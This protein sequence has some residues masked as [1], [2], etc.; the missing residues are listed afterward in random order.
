MIVGQRRQG[1]G[2]AGRQGVKLVDSGHVVPLL[3]EE[4]D[5]GGKHATVKRTQARTRIP[6]C[7]RPPRVAK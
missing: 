6:A 7:A 1:H 2:Q 3:Q 4:M 5:P